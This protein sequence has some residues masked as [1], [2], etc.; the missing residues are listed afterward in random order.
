M[1]RTYRANRPLI[2]VGFAIVLALGSTGCQAA[3]EAATPAQK[4]T[5]SSMQ[6]QGLLT[7]YA[8]LEDTLSQEAKLGALAFFLKVTFRR[9]VPEIDDL[10]HRLSDLSKK[11]LA[12]LDQL[13]ELAPEATDAPDFTDPIGSAITSAATDAGMDEML[14]RKAS[15][16]IRFVLLQAQALRM[17]SAISLS[18]A[19]IETNQRRKEW[20]HALSAE[21]ESIRDELVVV[22]ENY[23]NQEGAAQKG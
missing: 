9:P 6:H 15:F 3:K 8:L 16:G 5:R 19:E 4:S 13:R 17:I 1:S 18:A 14:D 23:I 2:S 11:R 12:E 21:Y 10:M 7:A 22:L 20:L